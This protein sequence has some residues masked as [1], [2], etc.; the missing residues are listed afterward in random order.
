M[1]SAGAGKGNVATRVRL[2]Y[3]DGIRSQEHNL[4]SRQLGTDPYLNPH[5]CGYDEQSANKRLHWGTLPLIMPCQRSP[6]AEWC[7]EGRPPG[8]G[9]RRLQP[10]NKAGHIAR[11]E[12]VIDVNDG[13]VAGAT[14]QHSK[15]RC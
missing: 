1:L 6:A 2:P 7:A 5:I 11:P 9:D 4:R 14:V 3:I 12:A 8:P 13:Y 15:Q 10:I